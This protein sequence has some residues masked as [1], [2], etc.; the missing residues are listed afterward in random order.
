MK[1]SFLALP[2]P[3]VVCILGEPTV[4]ASLATIRNGE[5][6]GARA[7][8]VHLRA[9]GEGNLTAENLRRIIEGTAHPVMALLYRGETAG[10]KNPPSDEAITRVLL[11]AASAGAAAVDLMADMFDA[12]PCEFTSNPKA[13]DS[14][15][16][17]ID[18]AHARGAEVVLSSH[19][20]QARSCDQVL[21]QM[22]A[23]EARGP[24][25]VKI[26]TQTDTEAEFLEAVRTTLALRQALKTPFIHLCTGAFARPHRFLGPTL[27]CAIT[28]CV[29]R[30]EAHYLSGQPPV[31]AMKQAL[32]AVAWQIDDVPGMG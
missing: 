8:A 32:E 29:T 24:D 3:A 1:R 16:R 23:M 31:R 14:Q 17:F 27:G 10:W 21:E 22:T 26:V 2:R 19:I 11:D 13:I 4:E 15:R 18:E 9:L 6:D 28:F 5:Y 25:Y 12:S 20:A 7:F 30:Y